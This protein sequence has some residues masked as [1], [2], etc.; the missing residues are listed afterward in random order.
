MV[1][2]DPISFQSLC[3][4]DPYLFVVSGFY[5]LLFT[6]TEM[7]LIKNIKYKNNCIRGNKR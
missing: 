5:S 4:V 1:I 6:K 2:I 3:Y 7:Y